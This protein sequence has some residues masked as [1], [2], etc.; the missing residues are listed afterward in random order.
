VHVVPDLGSGKQ[1]FERTHDV[2]FVL[3]PVV[4]LPKIVREEGVR[5]IGPERDR[6]LLGLADFLDACLRT[7]RE[8]CVCETLIVAASPSH[9][10]G[11]ST[12]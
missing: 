1:P 3:L 4:N 2:G 8:P 10:N 9:G 11:A 5:L 6:L 12:G 7:I